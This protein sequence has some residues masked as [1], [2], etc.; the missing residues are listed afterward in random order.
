MG[1]STIRKYVDIVCDVLIEKDKL[2]NKY[3]NILLSQSSK[4]I[5]ACFENLTCIHNI[6]GVIDGTYIP[7]AN[8]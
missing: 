1:A 5:N 7:L 8:L 4:D 2:F 3:I 6:C